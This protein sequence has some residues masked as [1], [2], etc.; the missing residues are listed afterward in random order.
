MAHAI[1]PYCSKNIEVDEGSLR[2]YKCNSC[3]NTLTVAFLREKDAFIDLDASNIEFQTGRMHLDEKDFDAA[4]ECFKKSLRFNP[5]NYLAEYYSGLC[6]ISQN[7][8]KED[9]SVPKTLSKMFISSVIKA[10][11]AQ[12]ERGQ[13][14][15]FITTLLSEVY[16]S[17]FG[18]YNDFSQRYENNDYQKIFRAKCIDFV[19]AVRELISLDGSLL[20]ISEKSVSASF[21]DIIDLAIDVCFHATHSFAEGFDSVN[22]PPDE[23]FVKVRDL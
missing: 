18:E 4:A 2:E 23:D 5:N 17:L 14:V 13:K 22:T 8:E 19:S 7:A 16:V 10:D 20:C 21:K 15:G 11:N 6:E 9:F 1:C 12:I 3:G